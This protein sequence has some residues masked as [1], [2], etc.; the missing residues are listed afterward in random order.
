[1]MLVDELINFK[2]RPAYTVKTNFKVRLVTQNNL[3]TV[4]VEQQLGK[5]NSKGRKGKRAISNGQ[6]NLSEIQGSKQQ[7]VRLN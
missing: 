3:A 1:M 5:R 7:E 6:K 4:Y 2:S